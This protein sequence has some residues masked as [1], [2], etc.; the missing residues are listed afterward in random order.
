[1]RRHPKLAELIGDEIRQAFV[2]LIDLCLDERVD[3]TLLA[4]DLC[5]NEENSVNTGSFFATQTRRLDE[6]D[7]RLVILRGNHDAQSEFTQDLVYPD[8]VKVLEPNSTPSSSNEAQPSPPA[9]ATAE[10]RPI[11]RPKRLKGKYK[12]QAEGAFDIG[13]MHTSLAD[14]LTMTHPAG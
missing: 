14:A 3:T 9:S 2:R 10:V 12:P 13:M 4:S 7:I 5:D 1:M 8:G 6:A 11:E